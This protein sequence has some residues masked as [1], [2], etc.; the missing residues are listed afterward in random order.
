MDVYNDLIGTTC[1]I[2]RSNGKIFCFGYT[3]IDKINF[4]ILNNLKQTLR[5]FFNLFR[6]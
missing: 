5:L 6:V 1:H 3:S 4:I 2:R